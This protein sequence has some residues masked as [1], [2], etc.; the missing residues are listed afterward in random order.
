MRAM[1]GTI[2]LS[3]VSSVMNG[4][5]GSRLPS[6]LT[7][8]QIAAVQSDPQVIQSFSLSLQDSVRTVY[9]DG[10]NLQFKIIIGFAAAQFLGAAL[11]WQKVPLRVG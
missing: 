3:I 9:G 2:G 11:M 5:L 8:Q 10:Y 4:W 1:G 6:L 7:P